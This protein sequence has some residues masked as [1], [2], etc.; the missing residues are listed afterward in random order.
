MVLHS[1]DLSTRCFRLF[2]SCFLFK[3]RQ[4]IFCPGTDMFRPHLKT[5]SLFSKCDV[6]FFFFQKAAPSLTGHPILSKKTFFVSSILVSPPVLFDRIRR[7]GSPNSFQTPPPKKEYAAC[8]LVLFFCSATEIQ[9]KQTPRHFTQKW[10]RRSP[11]SRG[12][13]L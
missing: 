6:L 10:P 11:S 4:C 1:P 3:H 13:T 12:T 9:I 5:I 7:E 2:F 8:C